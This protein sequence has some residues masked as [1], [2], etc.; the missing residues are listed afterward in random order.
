MARSRGSYVSLQRQVALSLT[1]RSLQRSE[2]ADQAVRPG[3]LGSLPVWEML[4]SDEPTA[5]ISGCR[6]DRTKSFDF[7]RL[8]LAPD[9][10]EKWKKI[11]CPE[12]LSL[13]GDCRTW[14]DSDR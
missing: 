7:R 8:E 5:L 2:N 4:G 13:T 11:Q 6:R 12:C 9:L 14:A 10:G 1:R 3:G